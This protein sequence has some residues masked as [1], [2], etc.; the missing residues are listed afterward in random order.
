MLPLEFLGRYAVTEL[1]LQ[2]AQG[3]FDRS[4]TGLSVAYAGAAARVG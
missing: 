4:F 2:A 3:H 1:R